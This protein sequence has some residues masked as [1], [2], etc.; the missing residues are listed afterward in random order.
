MSVKVQKS[1][2]ERPKT[3]NAASHGSRRC[4]LTAGSERF[5]ENQV[6]FPRGTLFEQKSLNL[7]REFPPIWL[8]V[9][10]KCDFEYVSVGVK[11]RQT[12]FET[13]PIGLTRKSRFVLTGGAKV[14]RPSDST[15]R[16]TGARPTIGACPHH[17]RNNRTLPEAEGREGEPI[18][19][20]N[21]PVNC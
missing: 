10:E 13:A 3:T 14:R 5:R 11:T 18:P 12:G 21:G 6:S 1:L 2:R 16:L 20:G 7:V 4:A 9:L 19:V 8:V 17:G 15:R